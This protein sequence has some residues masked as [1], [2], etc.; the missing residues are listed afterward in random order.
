MTFLYLAIYNLFYKL[1]Q[2]SLES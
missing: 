2:G 1:E